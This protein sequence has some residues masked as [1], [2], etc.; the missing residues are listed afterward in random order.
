[1]TAMTARPPISA[2]V[3]VFVALLVITQQIP[4]MLRV[5]SDGSIDG[6]RTTTEFALPSFV[7]IVRR[8]EKQGN[9]N[10]NEN[11]AMDTAKQNNKSNESI[12][13]ITLVPTLSESVL[14]TKDTDTDPPDC[15]NGTAAALP[16]DLLVENQQKNRFYCCSKS[17]DHDLD[18]WWQRHPT[19]EVSSETDQ[20][21]CF[22]PV[23]D[24][25][26]AEFLHLLSRLQWGQQNSCSNN[27]NTSGFMIINSGYSANV[28]LLGK[29][30]L[31]SFLNNR[32]FVT[33]KRV[34]EF[35]WRYAANQNGTPVCPSADLECYFL[36][37]SNCKARIKQDDGFDQK[38]I[39]R[40]GGGRYG[41]K[42]TWIRSYLFR[43][44]LWMRKKV[45]WELIRKT[46]A[47][48]L[49]CTAMHVR[50]TDAILEN[51]WKKRRHYFR[52]AD[53]LNATNPSHNNVVLLTDDQ[54]AIDEAL[55]L[56]YN[57]TWTF[58]NRT[59][60]RGTEGGMNGHV[61]SGDPA[62]E[63][64]VILAEQQLATH[65]EALVHTRS[66]YADV[67]RLAMDIARDFKDYEKRKIDVGRQPNS[68]HYTSAE[69]FFEK[70]QKD[71]SSP[72]H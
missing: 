42:V 22:S 59:R 72:I 35:I 15:F 46:P 56:H 37:I 69:E 34:P 53:Y 10:G 26:R 70:L 33:S 9:N 29:A 32:T 30:F 23:N 16:G 39:D 48:P 41:K 71:T 66:G 57:R 7:E 44:K 24:P 43:P 55:A 62:F 11:G 51:N 27:N 21:Y 14:S 50:R 36:P 40:H 63:I 6:T 1:M 17:W 31:T 20:R 61:P 68:T 45:Y 18:E 38:L 12:V 64:A 49:P 25:K 3:I 47:I 60:W 28:G 5:S 67:L 19:W 54:T 8:N 4:Y 58:I 52:I 2:L 65:C 13:P